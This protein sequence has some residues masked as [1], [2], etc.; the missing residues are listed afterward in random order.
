MDHAAGVELLLAAGAAV[1]AVDGDGQGARETAGG[2][3]GDVECRDD[4]MQSE[5]TV[6][7]TSCLMILNASCVSCA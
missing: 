3:D 4:L 1:D 6:S 2:D 7:V 5:R